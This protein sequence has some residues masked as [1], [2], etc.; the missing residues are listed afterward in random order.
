ME[1]CF[2]TARNCVNFSGADNLL[3]L[4]VV[5]VGM[6]GGGMSVGVLLNDRIVVGVIG[7]GT[8]L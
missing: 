4:L 8:I 3:L 2:I 7:N 6:E 1:C 5:L